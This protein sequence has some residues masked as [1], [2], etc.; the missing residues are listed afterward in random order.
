MG[1]VARFV[2]GW[3]VV[4]GL[5][6][7]IPSLDRWAVSH[8]VDSMGWVSRLLRWPFVAYDDALVIHGVSMQ[9]VPDCTPLMPTAAFAISVVAFPAPWRRRLIGIAVGAVLLWVY[10]LLRIFALIPV[11][12]YRPTWFDFIHVYLWQTT[13]LI[14]V[15][16]MFLIWLGTQTRRRTPVPTTT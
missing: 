15:F 16:A 2:G 6:A 10:N 9:I 8:T 14:V 5:V 11:L 4:L 7:W 1:F 12:K 3:A 13:T